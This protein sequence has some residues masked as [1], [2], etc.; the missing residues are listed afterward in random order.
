MFGKLKKHEKI[1]IVLLNYL[2]A[3]RL[4]TLTASGGPV[5]VGGF[6]SHR[7]SSGQASIGYLVPL[8]ISAISIQ[9]VAN[10]FNDYADGVAGRDTSQRLGPERVTSQG[11]CSANSIKYMAYLFSLLAL[12]SGIPIIFR[13]G[14][15]FLGLGILSLILAYFYTAT[16]WSLA[17]I[18]IADFFVVLFFGA[19]AVWGS[20]YILTLGSSLFPLLVGLQVGFLCNNLLIIN[21]LRD[22][23]E[24]RIHGKKTLPVRFGRLFGLLEYLAMI[25]GA[26]A[27]FFIWPDKILGYKALGA[28][29]PWLILSLMVWDWVRKNKPSSAYNKALKLSGGIHIGFCMSLALAFKIF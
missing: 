1:I 12:F 9:I 18:G 27:L 13:G 21:N 4:N 25:F 7:L 10:L 23:E 19:F 16:P 14:I 24:D 22:L 28:S 11:I 26:F 20:Y 6:L 8:F 15:L 3:C 5:L 2:K 29:V 17:S